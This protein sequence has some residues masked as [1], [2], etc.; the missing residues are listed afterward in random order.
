[1]R[2]TSGRER[3]FVSHSLLKS[4]ASSSSKLMKSW[5]S[6]YNSGKMFLLIVQHT[7]VIIYLMGQAQH[8]LPK[9]QVEKQN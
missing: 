1:M 2:L 7:F 5:R 4:S 9:L 3:V 6:W 8:N